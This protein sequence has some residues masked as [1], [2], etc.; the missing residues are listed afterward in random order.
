[1]SVYGELDLMAK[2]KTELDFNGKR[3]HIARV[4]MPNTAYQFNRLTLKY[5]MVQ[6]IMQLYRIPS[7][8]RLTLT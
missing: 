7:K 8:L 2:R 1:M 3:E 6:E 4:N 5:C